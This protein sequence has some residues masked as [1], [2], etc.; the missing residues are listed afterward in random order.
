MAK[1]ELKGMEE[2][3]KKLR[4]LGEDGGKICKAAVFDGADQIA[5]AIRASIE[6]MPTIGKQEAVIAWRNKEPVSG[7]TV[8]Q[9]QGLL[10]GLYLKKM[11]DEGGFIYT[12]VGFAGYN[13]VETQKYPSGQPNSLIARSMESGSSARR[14]K[15]FVRPAANKAKAAAQSRMEKKIVEMIDNIMN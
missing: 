9:K 6:S 7:I 3:T 12:Q 13:S 10:Q 4:Q 1:I 11:R 14:K 15:P 2:Y 8:E 5:D